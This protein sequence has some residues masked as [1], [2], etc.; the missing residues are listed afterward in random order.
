MF[1]PVGRGPEE[2]LTDTGG[3]GY[4]GGEEKDPWAWQLLP[5]TVMPPWG[6]MGYGGLNNDSQCGRGHPGSQAVR[7]VS[8]GGRTTHKLWGG[9]C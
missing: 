6:N 4:A 3:G 7:F 1:R 9:E 2:G 8:E 5:F